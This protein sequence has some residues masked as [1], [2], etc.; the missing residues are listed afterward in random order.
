MTL[1]SLICRAKK[2]VVSDVRGWYMNHQE[3]SLPDLQIEMGR[4]K[5]VGV[6]V[7]KKMVI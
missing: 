3:Q 7:S 1:V 2:R 6:P 5:H 4:T